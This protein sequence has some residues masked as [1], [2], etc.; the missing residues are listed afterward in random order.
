[1][2]VRSFLFLILWLSSVSL[3]GGER[4]GAPPMVSLQEVVIDHIMR[5][6]GFGKRTS[7]E[8]ELCGLLE[9]LKGGGYVE[10]PGDDAKVRPLFVTVQGLIEDACCE[11]LQNGK[12]SRV[13]GAIH[14]PCPATP[15]CTDGAISEKLV[16]TSLETDKAR[17]VT[18]TFRARVLR[19]YL[20][21]GG[22]LYVVYPRGGELKRTE[23]Q[24]AIYR[25]LLA[26]YPKALFDS[27]IERPIPLLLIGATYRITGR[28]GDEIV[29]GI[30]ATQANAP[31]DGT[32]WRLWFGDPKNNHTCH[33]RLQAIECLMGRVL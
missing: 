18:V 33:Q 24:L 19:D 13:S 15:L 14:T 25:G 28:A 27:P 1:M 20:K 9:E 10:R 16:H 17:L 31:A 22:R 7:F 26:A 5:E 3:W 30:G 12:L 2:R 11:L 23:S 29:F 32:L 4:E 8:K 21:Y 6:I